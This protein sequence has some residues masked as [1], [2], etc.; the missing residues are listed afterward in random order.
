MN[1]IGIWTAIARIF[2]GRSKSM[3]LKKKLDTKKNRRKR[4]QEYIRN[5]I[6]ALKYSIIN[7]TLNYARGDISQEGFLRRSKN[8]GMLILKRERYLSKVK[9]FL[10]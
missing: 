6:W 9:P 8:K 10:G 5:E 7:L 4:H 1:T 3:K 2:I